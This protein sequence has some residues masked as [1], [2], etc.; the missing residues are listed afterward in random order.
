MYECS[1]TLAIPTFLEK[2][3]QFFH[4]ENKKHES[5]LQVLNANNTTEKMSI[6]SDHFKQNKNFF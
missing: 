1:V 5:D 2:T 4:S 3:C 6:C